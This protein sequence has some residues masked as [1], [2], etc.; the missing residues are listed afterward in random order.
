MEV[1]FDTPLPTSGF[2]YS[3]WEVPGERIISLYSLSA[4]GLILDDETSNVT[5]LNQTSGTL[6]AQRYARG[7]FVFVE[8][9]VKSLYKVITPYMKEKSRLTT[10]DADFLD[11]AFSGKLYA[12]NLLVDRTKLKQSSEAWVHVKINPDAKN[13]CYTGF[14]AV[15]GILTWDNSD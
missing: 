3:P 4:L 9:E 1:W 12:K 11:A 10:E 6:C 7:V 14:N 8:N 13:S 2:R 5:Y 15:S